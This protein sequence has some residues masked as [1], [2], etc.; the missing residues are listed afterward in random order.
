LEEDTNLTCGG[1]VN[2]PA[3]PT[4]DERVDAAMGL[5]ERLDETPT[6]G[7]PAIYDDVHRRLQT[8]LADTEAGAEPD[9]E[10]GGGDVSTISG[11][12]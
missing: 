12:G 6:A 3:G 5:L 2:E 1:A 8:A 9:T 11:A 10:A 7:H 4:G